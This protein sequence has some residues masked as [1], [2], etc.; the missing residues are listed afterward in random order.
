[1]VELIQKYILQHRSVSIEGWGTM[2]LE[3]Q[4]AILDFPNRKLDAPTTKIVFRT[5]A[6]SSHSY[7]NWLSNE[8]KIKP[9]EASQKVRWFVEGF[10]HTITHRNIV[11]NGWGF[12][13]KNGTGVL[14]TPYTETDWQSAPIT[15]E[16]VMHKG[17]GHQVRVGEDEKN[18]A[19]ME[20]LLHAPVAKE[21]HLGSIIALLFTCA[22]IILAVVFAGKHN[23]QWKNHTNHQ[24]L[25]LKDPPV[26]YKIH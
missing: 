8:L 17:A 1:L 19:E 18:S 12:F 13:E 24:E 6:K 21:K 5:D 16:R 20:E 26:L 7:S 25:Q 9:D 11:W 23:I 15:A 22:G 10:G 2:S 3:N 4:P 14:F